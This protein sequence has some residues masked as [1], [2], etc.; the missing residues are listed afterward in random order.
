MLI[1]NLRDL[2]V[3]VI[4]DQTVDLRD[5]FRFD[6]ADFGDGKRPLKRQCARGTTRQ[7]NMSRDALLLDQRHILDEQTNDAFT[8]AN[9][10]MFIVP[11]LR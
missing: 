11:D 1:E 7:P 9:A 2:A 4:T 5:D 10:D 6:L 8:F 3:A